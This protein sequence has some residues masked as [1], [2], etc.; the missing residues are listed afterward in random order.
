MKIYQVVTLQGSKLYSLEELIDNF[1]ITGTQLS[2][3]CREE[4]QGEPKLFGLLGPMYNGVQDGK[5]V[6]RYET[7]SYY[8]TMD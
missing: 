2:I 4:L 6:I 1:K 8:N 3:S 5:T 7:Q